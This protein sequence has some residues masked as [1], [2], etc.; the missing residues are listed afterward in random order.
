[1]NQRPYRYVVC[2]VFTDRALEGNAL[3]VFTDAQGLDSAEMQRL[4]RETNLS[5]TTFVLPA[6]QGGD[7]RVRIFTPRQELP[8]AGHPTLGTAFVLAEMNDRPDVQLELGVG[9]VVVR[10]SREAGLPKFG[11]MHQ[12]YPTSE[13]FG[14][15]EAVL[16]AL[17]VT[18]STLPMLVYDN[19]QR[20]VLVG[21][22]S[23]QLLSALEPDLRALQQM[24]AGVAAFAIEGEAV[25]V[26]YF[27]P[28]AGVPEDPATGSAAGPLALHLLRHGSWAGG[29][30]L[31]IEQGSG[32]GRPSRLFARVIEDESAPRVEVGGAAVVVA[33]GEFL[34]PSV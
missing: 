16:T 25:S 30:E 3:C 5:E 24:K 10:I 13:P 8:F 2:D 34:V 9:P 18:R 29:R 31:L 23:G 33:R 27:A 14:Q 21:V 28:H 17:G 4:A 12:P 20:H 6:E 32:L 26:R 22:E 15:P 19:G 11:W 7:A 1:M